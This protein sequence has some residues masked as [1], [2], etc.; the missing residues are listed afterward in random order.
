M[1][2]LIMHATK[3]RIYFSSGFE[4]RE[5]LRC[6]MFWLGDTSFEFGPEEELL[7][8]VVALCKHSLSCWADRSE[9]QRYTG[10]TLL[11]QL[12]GQE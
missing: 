5:N 7:W 10:V 6:D 11:E 2:I 9:A 8:E 1:P 4:R 12:G 3:S